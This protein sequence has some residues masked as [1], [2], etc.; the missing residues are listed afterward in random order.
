MSTEAYVSTVLD[1]DAPSARASV[2]RRATL[3]FGGVWAV[4]ARRRAA[5]RDYERLMTMSDHQ[6]RD[7]GVTRDDIRRA[8]AEPLRLFDR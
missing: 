7:I 8:M 2:W 6:L 1:Y 3:V 4:I 5:Q